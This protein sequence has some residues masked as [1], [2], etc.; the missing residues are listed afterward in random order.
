MYEGTTGAQGGHVIIGQGDIALRRVSDIS[1]DA[2]AKRLTLAYGEE[3]GHFHELLGAIEHQANGKRYVVLPE[4]TTLR[5][6]PETHA[7]RH[8]PIVVPAGTYEVL[9][10]SDDRSLWAGQRE[11]TPE[12]IRNAG[13]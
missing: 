12:V 7:W 10:R 1:T 3:S 8:D 9:G 6:G 4:P 13:D 5:V 2:P 11:Y